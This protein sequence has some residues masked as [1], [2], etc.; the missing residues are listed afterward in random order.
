M[1]R[2]DIEGVVGADEELELR[3]NI[4]AESTDNAEDDGRPGRNETRGRGDG[5]ETGDG[6]RAETDDGP[7]LLEAVIEQHPGDGT[8]GCGEVGDDASHDGAEVRGEGR[9]AVEAEPAHPEKD[10]AKDDMRHIVG[11]VGQA[12]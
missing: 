11:A 10:G 5:D 4:A 12:S 7:F 3:R 9:A 8:R 1:D 2:E 6:A